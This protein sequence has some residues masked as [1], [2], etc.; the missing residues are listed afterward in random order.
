MVLSRSYEILA[1]RFLDLNDIEFEF[2]STV[3]SEKFIEMTMI[4]F[5]VIME[6]IYLV[7]EVITSINEG[8]IFVG[9]EGKDT[10]VING[11]ESDYIFMV[12]NPGSTIY[13]AIETSLNNGNLNNEKLLVLQKQ[14]IQQVTFIQTEVIDLPMMVL[15]SVLIKSLVRFLVI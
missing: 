5:L 13:E 1:N 14:L 12:E 10:A 15:G 4:L 11:Q 7:G 8:D 2:Q 6:M 3:E 9:G